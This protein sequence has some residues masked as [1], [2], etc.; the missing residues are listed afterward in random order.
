MENSPQKIKKALIGICREQLQEAYQKSSAQMESLRTALGSEVKSSAGDK[1]ETGRAM[2]Q[3]EM[4][5]TASRM[6]QQEEQ[7]QVFERQIAASKD[8][9]TIVAPGCLVVTDEGMY[10]IAVSL[11][12]V[13][14]LGHRV[15]VLSL[16]SPI[17]QVLKG[18]RVGEAFVFKGKAVRITAIV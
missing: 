16:M 17:G 18:K 1:H 2:I 5:R 4:E 10:F 13:E 9:G 3:L 12:L 15:P 8:H 14:V 7:L 11:G 6:G